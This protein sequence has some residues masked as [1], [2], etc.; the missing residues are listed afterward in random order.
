MKTKNKI[1][2]KIEKKNKRKIKQIKPSSLFTTVS[3][4]HKT[5]KDIIYIVF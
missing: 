5:S 2:G 3:L 1:K 4:V